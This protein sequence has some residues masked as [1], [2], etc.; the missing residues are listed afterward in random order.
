[1]KARPP[2]DAGEAD[3]APPVAICRAVRTR[4]P[5]GPAWT[6]VIDTC[7]LCGLSHAH[8]GGSG[9]RPTYGDRLS[10]CAD[11]K[12]R[13]AYELRPVDGAR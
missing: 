6:L 9:A 10:H 4:T 1:M 13:R 5:S 7:P 11:A 2:D 12:I 3:L 8:G